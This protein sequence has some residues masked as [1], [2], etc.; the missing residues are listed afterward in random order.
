MGED[1]QNCDCYIPDILSMLRR[2]QNET[3]GASPS[4]LLVGD[5]QWNAEPSEMPEAEQICRKFLKR[6]EKAYKTQQQYVTQKYSMQ[7]S[8]KLSNLQTCNTVLLHSH[9][10]GNKAAKFHTVFYPNCEGPH[11][12]VEHCENILCKR[13]AQP[14]GSE[15]NP[16]EQR[17]RQGTPPTLDLASLQAECEPQEVP[18]TPHL[19]LL[20]AEHKC[21]EVLPTPNLP[22]QV[23]QSTE[24]LPMTR[25]VA[26]STERITL[27][28]EPAHS[29]M[30]LDAIEPAPGQWMADHQTT[31]DQTCTLTG[32]DPALALLRRKKTAHCLGCL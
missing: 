7:E 11:T 1:H 20:Q 6:V 8:Q 4:E 32:P 31:M 24:T 14:S 21:Q 23:E 22:L 3:T 15:Q 18:P 13:T 27:T 5:T 28:L 12:I 9:F 17:E 16:P 25:P 29:S 19:L 10:L 30:P 26:E 2:W